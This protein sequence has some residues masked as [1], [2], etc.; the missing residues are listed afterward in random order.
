[1]VNVEHLETWERS[2]VEELAYKA[3]KIGLSRPKIA[4]D[5]KS[6]R[7]SENK[8]KARLIFADSTL[9]AIRNLVD[10]QAEDKGLWFQAETAAEAYLQQ[11]LRRLHALIEVDNEEF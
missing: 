3:Y 2:A 1:M 7:G 11:E 5:D 9:A 6:K 8:Y 4:V 10:R